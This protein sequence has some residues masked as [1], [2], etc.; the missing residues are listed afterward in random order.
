MSTCALQYSPAINIR[1][2]LFIYYK[3]GE[4]CT[5]AIGEVPCRRHD[6]RAAACGTL[7]P[8]RLP[9]PSPER[10]T[11]SG[12]QPKGRSSP[13]IFS[14]S[15]TVPSILPVWWILFSALLSWVIWGIIPK[16]SK[17]N[18]CCWR[19]GRWGLQFSF[20]SVRTRLFSK[21]RHCTPPQRC[22]D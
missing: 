2:G 17:L 7:H 11:L 16:V 13:H 19:G 5:G 10:H 4:L 9:S 14:A 22:R 18:C 21:Q 1:L 20:F 3:P 8:L 15:R 12:R 6:V